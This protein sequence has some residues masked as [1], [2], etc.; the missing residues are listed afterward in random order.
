VFVDL[1]PTV[2]DEVRVGTYRQLFHPEQLITGTVQGNRREVQDI[3]VLSISGLSVL[4]RNPAGLWCA[5]S[6]LRQ[7]F[8]VWVFTSL[9]GGGGGGTYSSTK[10]EKNHVFQRFSARKEK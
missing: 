4:Y 1:E 6:I 3:F 10:I 5:Q 2:V 9:G 8:F 7:L